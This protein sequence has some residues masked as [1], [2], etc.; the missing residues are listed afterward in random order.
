MYDDS[1]GI[2]SWQRPLKNGDIAVVIYN[3][4]EKNDKDSK[5]VE[6]TFQQLRDVGLDC[7][8]NMNIRD[9]WAKKDLGTFTE[10]YSASLARHDVQLLR[11]SKA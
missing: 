1:T 8:D 2:Q 5:T 3:A 10:K 7:K 11:L 6:F 4:D 9:L